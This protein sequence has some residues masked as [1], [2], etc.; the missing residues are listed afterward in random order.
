MLLIYD[1]RHENLSGT[2]RAFTV[3]NMIRSGLTTAYATY[4]PVPACP[5]NPFLPVPRIDRTGGHAV[6]T[7]YWQPSCPFLSRL[8]NFSLSMGT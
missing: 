5:G 8:E 6:W 7:G 3:A 1:G 4:I 2:I